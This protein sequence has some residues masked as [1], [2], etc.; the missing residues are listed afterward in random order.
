MILFTIAL[1]VHPH[2]RGDN[3]NDILNA[4]TSIG[5]PPR[6]WGQFRIDYLVATYDRFTP[7]GVGTMRS[8]AA[9]GSGSTVHPHGR[10]DN[11]HA[12]AGRR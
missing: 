6:A 2:G 3:M 12:T 9:A 10:G 5:S 7:T 4:A 1:A 8:G 11:R